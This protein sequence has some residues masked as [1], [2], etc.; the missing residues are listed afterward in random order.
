MT[1]TCKVC[2]ALDSSSRE[3]ATALKLALSGELGKAEIARVLTDNGYPTT[4]TSV[5]RHI[6]NHRKP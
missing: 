4:E 3:D 6:T 5:R 1:N 2:T